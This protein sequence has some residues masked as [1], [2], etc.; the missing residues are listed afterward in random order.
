MTF[1]ALALGLTLSLAAL[2]SPA[3]EA[4]LA[5]DALLSA[6]TSEVIAV[7]KHDKDIQAGNPAKVAALVEAKILPHFDFLRMTRIAVARNWPLASAEQ[8]K[9]L[10]GEFQTLLV[11]TYSTALSRYR[12]Q[13][14]EFK[15]LHAAPG[16]TEV[17]VKSEVKQ[18]GAEATKIDYAME[19][20][21]A[22]WK[23]YDMTIAGV[24]LVTAYRETFADKVREGG[25]DG[26]IRSLADKNGRGAV[27]AG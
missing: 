14:I 15:P 10:A 27:R 19:K 12:D 23:V 8:Q 6:V 22:G 7:I 1:A 20:T 16:D 17:T 24:S 5:P 25:V 9:A 18:P 3:A 2:D 13:A 26:L 11:R 4:A 21:P